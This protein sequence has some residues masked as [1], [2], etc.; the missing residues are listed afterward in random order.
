MSFEVFHLAAE[1]G[2][3]ASPGLSRSVLSGQPAAGQHPCPAPGRSGLWFFFFFFGFIV[4]LEKAVGIQGQAA[5]VTGDE[6][7]SFRK[8]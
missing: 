2:P 4:I 3:C 6:Q 8:A 1:L 7:R 5:E